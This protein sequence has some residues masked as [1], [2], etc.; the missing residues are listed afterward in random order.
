MSK[1]AQAS[2]NTLAT[3]LAVVD[4]GSVAAAA[5][6]LGINHATVLRR[7]ADFERHTNLRLFDKSTR[8]YQ[9]APDRRAIIEAMREAYDALGQVERMI[10]ADRPRLAGG[11]RVTTT[12][13]FSNFLLPP[14][15]ASYAKDAGHEIELLADNAH[16]DFDRMEAHLTVRPAATLPAELEGIKA[17]L[18]HFGVYSS[19][20]SPSEA[21]LGLSG[22]LSRS[23]AADWLRAKGGMPLLSAGSFL[24]LAALAAS[25]AGRTVLPLIVGDQWS[26]L[27]RVDIP[28]ELQPVP[29]WVAAHIDYAR[30]G[31]INRARKHI[32]QALRATGAL[33]P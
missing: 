4:E 8:G 17:G 10:E 5:R 18:L 26:G 6:A 2:W 31:R 14:I 25:G 30:S 29:V 11:L 27:E 32:A 15:I 21:W 19:G 1:H 9:L 24:S 28:K 20:N 13:T 33:D 3:I 22:P 16:L 12:D 7:I 23:V